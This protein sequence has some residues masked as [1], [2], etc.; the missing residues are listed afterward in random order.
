MSGGLPINTQ[1]LGYSHA[2]W[3]STPNFWRSIIDPEDKARITAEAAEHFQ[4]ERVQRLD[5]VEGTA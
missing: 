5:T 3:T 1:M 4:L 2:E